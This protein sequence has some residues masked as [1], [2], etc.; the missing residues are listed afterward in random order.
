MY[1][2]SSTVG[3][4]WDFTTSFLKVRYYKPGKYIGDLNLPKKITKKVT[5][6]DDFFIINNK[7]WQ[8]FPNLMLAVDLNA[9]T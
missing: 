3:A 8:Q 4:G 9:D 5:A 6:E 1:R 7:K 2:G